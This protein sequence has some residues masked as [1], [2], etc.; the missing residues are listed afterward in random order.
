MSLAY[1][2]EKSSMADHMARESFITALGDAEFETKIRE[3][4]P[5]NLEEAARRALRLEA[6]KMKVETNVPDRP[7]V[8]R[9]VSNQIDDVSPA[10][11]SGQTNSNRRRRGARN[12]DEFGENRRN[13]NNDEQSRTRATSSNVASANE[14]LPKA[15]QEALD[16]H[17]RKVTAESEETRRQLDRFLYL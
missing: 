16:A 3:G 17:L 8:N 13:P 6:I 1:P 4:E 2:G 5:K 10:R 15:V 11:G 14:D 12:R 9:Y 7:K